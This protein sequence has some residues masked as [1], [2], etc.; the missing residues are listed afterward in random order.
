MACKDSKIVPK[1]DYRN[2]DSLYSQKIIDDSIKKALSESNGL[3][4]RLIHR[5]N[6]LEDSIAFESIHALLP[7]FEYFAEVI[8][9][10]LK[11]HL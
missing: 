5:Y 7:E 1:D 10:W 11:S 3:R 8:N 4:N 2:I 6:G 9:K